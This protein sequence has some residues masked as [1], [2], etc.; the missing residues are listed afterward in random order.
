MIF[1]VLVVGETPAAMTV[2]ALLV[3]KGLK[4]AWVVSP[5]NVSEAG[6]GFVNP[7]V[8]ALVWDLLPH[9]LI[10]EVLDRLGVPYKHIEKGERKSS[11]IQIVSPGFRTAL[12]DGIQ[13]FRRE[14][15]RIFGMSDSEMDKILQRK[16]SDAEGEFLKRYWGPLFRGSLPKKSQPMAFLSIGEAIAY[17]PFVM[18]GIRMRPDLKRLFELA[19]YSQSYLCQWV[20]PR[21]LVRHFIG[22]LSQLNIFAQG[23]LVAPD[24]VLQ[25]VFRMGGGEVFTAEKDIFIEPHNGKGVSIWLN[26]DEVVNG[27]FCLMAVSPEDAPQVFEGLNGSRRWFAKEGEDESSYKIANITFSIDAMGIPGGMGRDLILY[28]GRSKDPF[29]P[30]HLSFLSLEGSDREGYEG[31][32][33]V[34]YN[35]EL[36]TD[37]LNNWAERQA[38]RLE[39]LFPF[40]TSYITIRDVF[41]PEGHSLSP[42]RYF[43]ESTQKRRLGAMRLKEGVPGKNFRY[44]GRRQLD[45]MGLEGEIITG[46][47]AYQWAVERLSKL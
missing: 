11:G 26:E 43:Y 28:N 8:P 14:L 30:L 19:V 23:R 22:N 9:H 24:R 37:D 17:H 6:E 34:F 21:S 10:R 7:R 38:N 44:I 20:F 31:N 33:T 18:E 13:E 2:A 36:K 25:E 35:G 47:K 5:A 3:R 16:R 41:V 42:K 29:S 15:K 12:I 32:Y 27:T 4:V 45:Y 40:M 39:D 46:L 1:D